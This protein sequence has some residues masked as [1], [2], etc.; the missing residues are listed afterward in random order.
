M[1]CNNIL[2]IGE[3]WDHQRECILD[4]EHGGLH[5]DGKRTWSTKE[6]DEA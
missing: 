2:Y 6:S 3:V 4:V 1:K 5:S